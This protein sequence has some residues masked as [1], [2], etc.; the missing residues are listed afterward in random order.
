MITRNIT[1]KI[2]WYNWSILPQR[3]N[4][5][6][7]TYIHIR[8]EECIILIHLRAI[9]PQKWLW[10]STNQPSSS[11]S[12]P[13]SAPPHPASPEK[14]RPRREQG[15]PA[16]HPPLPARPGCGSWEGCSDEVTGQLLLITWFNFDEKCPAQ[17]VRAQGDIF[18]LPRCMPHC[19]ESLF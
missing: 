11:H 8:Q 12:M 17:V 15:P 5:C 9:I 10:G 3:I 6:H 19:V 1:F 13:P 2:I 16:H 4:C 14:V 18:I 7:V